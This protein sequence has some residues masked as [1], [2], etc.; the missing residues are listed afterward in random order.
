M[1]QL[2]IYNQYFCLWLDV[3]EGVEST[4]MEIL[5]LCKKQSSGIVLFP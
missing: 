2:F 3:M 1:L 5:H 4:S